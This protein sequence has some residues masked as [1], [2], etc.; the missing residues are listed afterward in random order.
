MNLN[1]RSHLKKKILYRC[2]KRGCRESEIILGNFL[3]QHINNTNNDLL[4]D[5]DLLLSHD[6][7][8]ILEWIHNKKTPPLKLQ[9]LVKN[10]KYTIKDE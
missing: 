6:D 7:N 8:E 1:H 2:N 10:I 4:S 3:K 5:L 9:E